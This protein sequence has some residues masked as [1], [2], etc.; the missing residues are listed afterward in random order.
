MADGWNDA[1][2]SEFLQKRMLRRRGGRDKSPLSQGE[3]RMMR[4]KTYIGQA[5]MGWFSLVGIAGLVG[6]AS[7]TFMSLG[8]I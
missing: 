1:R 6:A 4:P 3:T 7:L 5:M 2:S 8:H